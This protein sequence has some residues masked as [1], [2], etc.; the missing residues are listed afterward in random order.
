MTHPHGTGGYLKRFNVAG[1]VRWINA[2]S[3]GEN[4]RRFISRYTREGTGGG[5]VYAARHLG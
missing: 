3:G 4:N 5:G 1:K 2:Q